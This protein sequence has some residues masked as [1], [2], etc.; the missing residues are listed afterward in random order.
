M[1]HGGE[2][3]LPTHRGGGLPIQVNLNVDGTT[4]ARVLVDPLRREARMFER[5][6]GRSAF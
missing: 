4:L 2:T 6:N 1:A 5:S 3:V